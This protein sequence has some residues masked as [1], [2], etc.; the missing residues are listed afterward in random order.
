MS[1]P[2]KWHFDRFSRFC[3]AH[4]LMQWLDRLMVGLFTS[5]RQCTGTSLLPSNAWF[6]IER[7]GVCPSIRHLNPFSC[8]GQPAH[9]HRARMVQL[10]SPGGANVQQKLIF[11]SCKQ[12]LVGPVALNGS[13]CIILLNFMKRGRTVA[14]MAISR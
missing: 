8:F 12:H 10:Y 3:T 7:I 2:S 4:I 6:V 14:E 13:I 9:G 1:Q 11:L 5:L